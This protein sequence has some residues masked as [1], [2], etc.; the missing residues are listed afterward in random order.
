[1]HLT[2]LSISSSLKCIE[3]DSSSRSRQPTCSLCPIS[4]PTS[5]DI[6]HTSRLYRNVI[7]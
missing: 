3:T 7:Q 6:S 1:M 5:G 2:V 4:G